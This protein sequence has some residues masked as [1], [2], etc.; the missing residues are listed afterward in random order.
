M[1]F[2][3]WEIFL[4]QHGILYPV[5]ALTPETAD[6]YIRANPGNAV[7]AELDGVRFVGRPDRGHRGDDCEDAPAVRTYDSMHLACLDEGMHRLTCSY[8]YTIT[9]HVSPHTAFRTRL[10][11]LKFLEL[12][13]LAVDGEL[14]EE[15]GTPACFRVRGSYRTAMHTSLSR[16]YSHAP[17]A[18]FQTIAMS[19]GSYTLGLITE[20]ADGLRTVHTLNPNVVRP[21]FDWRACD[22]LT[23][24]GQEAFTTLPPYAGTVTR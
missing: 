2:S 15:M 20:E 14:P 12:R 4:R 1:N 6:A 11:L 16:F 5:A 9:E 21:I 7:I 19:N 22:A 13:G 18:M 10:A 24:A 8:W 17:G 3:H 23:D